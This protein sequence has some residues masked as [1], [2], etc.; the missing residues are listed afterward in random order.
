MTS[1]SGWSRAIC[2]KTPS[3]ASNRYD[4]EAAWA[5]LPAGVIV[6][7]LPG[8]GVLAVEPATGARLDSAANLTSPREVRASSPSSRTASRRSPAIGA[9][10][11]PT[12]PTAMHAPRSTAMPRSWARRETS[13]EKRVLPTPASPE[14]RRW[15]APLTPT[16]SRT[17]AA[18]SNSS[19]RPTKTGLTL[20]PGIAGS[21]GPRSPGSGAGATP[22]AV[23]RMREHGGEP[24][25]ETGGPRPADV[26]FSG[27]GRCP[28]APAAE[29][30]TSSARAVRRRKGPKRAPAVREAM[31]TPSGPRWISAE[32]RIRSSMRSWVRKVVSNGLMG[33]GLQGRGRRDNRR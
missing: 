11:R 13:S 32:V 9:Y 4:W 10:G 25:G 23:A 2:W 12:P 28:A 18:S 20:L 14:I 31:L 24:R 29:P 27:A 16:P 6:A 33:D 22:E 17:D 3:R 1:S 26:R 30:E 8:A 5:T 15:V 7:G 19:D 21:Y